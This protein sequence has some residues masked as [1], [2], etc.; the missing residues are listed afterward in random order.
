MIQKA[1][2]LFGRATTL[3]NNTMGNY[4]LALD[5][6]NEALRLREHYKSSFEEISGSMQNIG[7]IFRFQKQWSTAQDYFQRSLDILRQHKALS[8]LNAARVY[9]SLAFVIVEQLETDKSN[10]RVTVEEE[11]TKLVEAREYCEKARAI[12]EQQLG[13][14]HERTRDVIQFITRI[15]ALLAN[16]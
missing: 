4:Q 9:A 5:D 1:G 13:D 16:L 7:F 12:R 10:G 11:R 8:G 3:Y 15:D 2:I 14:A 6:H